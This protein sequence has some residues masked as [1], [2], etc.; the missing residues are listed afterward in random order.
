MTCSCSSATRQMSS[1]DGGACASF[2]EQIGKQ[3][4]MKGIKS[5]KLHDH[6]GLTECHTNLLNRIAAGHA[7]VTNQQETLPLQKDWRCSSLRK[8]L[9]VDLYVKLNKCWH[10]GCL[11]RVVEACLWMQ[12]WWQLYCCWWWLCKRP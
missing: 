2:A 1:A 5:S 9:T 3:K 6:G 7:S 8:S 12:W 10:S 11:F 4:F